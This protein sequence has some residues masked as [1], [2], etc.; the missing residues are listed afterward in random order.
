[1]TSNRFFDRRCPVP[2][3]EYLVGLDLGQAINHTAIAVLERAVVPLEQSPATHEWS[4]ETRYAFRHLEQLPLGIEYPDMVQHVR[5]LLCRPELADRS[6]LVVDATGPGRPVKDMLRQA[7]LPADIMAVSITS[8]QRETH[9]QSDWCVPKRDLITGL[10]VRFQAGELDI[11]GHLPAAE[12]FITELGNMRIK[13][14][15]DG[16][17]TYGAGRANE[18]DDLVLAAAL[19]C[20]AAFRKQRTARGLMKPRQGRIF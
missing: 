6:T 13:V 4:T 8:G 9:E 16:H 3:T 7:R 15:A 1:M 10:L 18:Q 19:A 14:S 17:E 5:Q 20:W 11:C 2:E 12:T